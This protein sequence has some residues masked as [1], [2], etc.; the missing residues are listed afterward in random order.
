MA[1]ALLRADQRQEAYAEAQ[2]ARRATK[3]PS[4]MIDKMVA[5]T[6]YAA[7]G[8]DDERQA[9]LA[10]ARDNV[11]RYPV[12]RLTAMHYI[13]LLQ[14][15][16]LHD[17]A[18]AF[19]REQVAI[20]RSDSV[21]FR[22]LATSY[23]AMN[24]RTL[25]HQAVGEMY[26]LMGAIPAAA[27]QLQLARQAADADFYVLS[28]VDARLRQLTARIEDQRREDAKSGRREEKQRSPSPGWRSPG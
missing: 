16:R 1:Y 15:S 11:G 9:A 3:A 21:Y 2:A 5:E 8:T 10:M 12:S 27:E 26:V 22:L 18:V 4:A 14:R 17:Q 23:G 20:S 25:Q 7:A 19:L 24:R 28:E 13:D 6:R